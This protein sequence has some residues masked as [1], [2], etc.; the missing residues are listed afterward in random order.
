MVELFIRMKK[1]VLFVWLLV[2]LGFF[3]SCVS[4]SPPETAKPPPQTQ[5]PP[6][7]Q[8]TPDFTEAKARAMSAMD[9]ARSVKAEVSVKASYDAAFSAYT[10]AESLEAVGSAGGIGK[11][12]EAET[13]FLTAYDEAKVKQEEA[14]RQ[15]SRARDAIKTVED[16]AA[17]FD[18]EYA[19]NSR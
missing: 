2:F 17:E 16:A 11:Y 4:P 15:L 5:A 14:R 9:K 8:E 12:L 7:K 6:E 13:A 3:S 1:N 10:E 18:R 19:E